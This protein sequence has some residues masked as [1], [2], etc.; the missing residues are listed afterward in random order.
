MFSRT[1]AAGKMPCSSLSM[2]RY[3]RST[4]GS[5][6]TGSMPSRT[7]P[8]STPSMSSCSAHRLSIVAVSSGSA[9]SSA[10][11]PRSSPDR[12]VGADVHGTGQRTGRLG[13]LFVLA[14][15][16]GDERELA[17]TTVVTHRPLLPARRAPHCAGQVSCRSKPFGPFRRP[18]T[19]TPWS[20]RRRLQSAALAVYTGS[21][22]PDSPAAERRPWRLGRNGVVLIQRP[23]VTRRRLRASVRAGIASPPGPR[24]HDQRLP[25]LQQRRRPCRHIRGVSPGK[26]RRPP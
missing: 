3:N 7:A 12:H 20:V 25:A 13:D 11:R 4:A 16:A 15:E 5:T 22:W 18:S 1:A 17:A 6:R 24:G 26:G 9:R 21:G 10:N 23:V 19:D 14:G 8:R 2:C